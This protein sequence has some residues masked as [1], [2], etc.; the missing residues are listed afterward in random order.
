[1]PLNNSRFTPRLACRVTGVCTSSGA[2]VVLGA[3]GGDTDPREYGS[4][5]PGLTIVTP[6]K[7]RAS[8]DVAGDVEEHLAVVLPDAAADDRLLVVPRIPR[9]PDA[10]RDVQRSRLPRRSLP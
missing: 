2:T 3:D 9:E 8:M 10:R 5:K 6:V 7:A 1:M 4:G